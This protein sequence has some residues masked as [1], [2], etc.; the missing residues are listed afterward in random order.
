MRRWRRWSGAPAVAKLALL[1]ILWS[2]TLWRARAALQH[3]AKRPMWTAF[4][5]LAVSL[6]SE[7][8]Q[9]GPHLDAVMHVTNISALIKQLAGMLAAAAVLEWVISSTR[10]TRRLGRVLAWRHVITGAAMAALGAL[11]AFVPRI[12]SSSFI[13]TAPGHPVTIAYEMVWLTYLGTAM[14][15]AATMFAVARHRS[16]GQGASM[17]ASFTL[18]AI[19]TGLGVVYS[20]SRISILA[21]SL[22]GTASATQSDAGFSA[23]EALQAAA[24]L[25]I[26]AGTCVPAVA[27]AASLYRDRRTLIALRPL[28]E[29]VTPS[30]PDTVLA[31]ASADD[32]DPRAFGLTSLRLI[33]RT[34]EIRDALGTLYEYCDL[35]PAPYA[36]AFATAE[37]LT[38]SEKDALVEAVTI[39]YALSRL[40]SGDA[41][42]SIV[43]AGRGGAADLATEV[44]WLLE[45]SRALDNHLRMQGALNAVRAARD[46]KKGGGSV[47]TVTP[48][49]REPGSRTSA[50]RKI[51][52][53][54]EPKNWILLDVVLI[55]T[56]VDGWA[57]LGWGLLG[58]LFAAVL[59]IWFIKR[60]I[61]NDRWADRHVGARRHRLVVMS[62]IIASVAVGIALL[63]ALGAPRPITA[64]I[65]SMLTTLAALMA[66]TP[67]WKISVHSAVSSGSVLLIALACGWW[68]LALYPLV[69]LVGW[70]RVALRDHT[71]NQ[72]LAGALVGALVATATYLPLR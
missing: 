33:H 57:G 61:R 41:G 40:P 30:R 22:A 72:V 50:A 23:T 9:V 11:F 27:K 8:P 36:E 67:V 69:A 20:V 15:C 1:F 56:V 16:G 28:W 49:S 51:T 6:T 29:L 32:R 58:A 70:S 14:L 71:R 34:V 35:D 45:V 54:L 68:A 2:V 10:P 52:D 17:R 64:L 39:R 47:N 21:A 53:L 43:K 59:P 25:L 55:G 18:L 65:V 48:D 3:P 13:D 12:E 7:L 60:G 46:E 24:I 66:V 62:F 44:Q 19:G 4:A 5:A 38:G 42:H 63:V 26:L 31:I 37:G